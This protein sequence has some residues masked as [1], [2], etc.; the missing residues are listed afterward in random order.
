[1]KEVVEEDGEGDT[2]EES[3]DSRIRGNE[4]TRWHVGSYN[5]RVVLFNSFGKELVA[6]LVVEIVM[7]VTHGSK[8]RKP[9]ASRDGFQGKLAVGRSH[10]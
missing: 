5:R 3:D 10:W 2:V 8:E 7:S 4:R 1:M 6:S 9:V